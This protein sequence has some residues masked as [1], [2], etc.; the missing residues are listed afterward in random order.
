MNTAFFTQHSL[1]VQP[2][3]IITPRL[4]TE[5]IHRPSLHLLSEDERN[6]ILDEINAR[7]ATQR[8]HN[9]DAEA[10]ANAEGRIHRNTRPQCHE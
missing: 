5:P 9:I 7:E 8:Q 4:V 1:V 6:R 10:E 2:R 3:E